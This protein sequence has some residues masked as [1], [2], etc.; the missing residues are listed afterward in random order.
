[1]VRTQTR[2]CSGPVPTRP[3]ENAR[4]VLWWLHTSA[5]LFPA[6]RHNLDQQQLHLRTCAAGIDRRVCSPRRDDKFSQCEP[7][8]L[9]QFRQ[10]FDSVD[11]YME[12]VFS[13]LAHV[14]YT[15][16]GCTPGCPDY[17]N[18]GGLIPCAS[19][20]RAVRAIDAMVFVQRTTATFCHPNC[21]E[22][23]RTSLP[24]H[25]SARAV[26]GDDVCAAADNI[27]ATLGVQVRASIS[28]RCAC[29][30]AL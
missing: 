6:V 1:M 4:N 9:L 3:S 14:D 26:V 15:V 20:L 21:C 22:L 29:R 28:R 7:Q 27:T 13:T 18:Y 16:A 24:T 8:A 19:T 30:C 10:D 2:S 5:T 25:A 12:Q 17:Q 23:S 11:M